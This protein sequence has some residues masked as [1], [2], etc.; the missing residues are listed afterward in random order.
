MRI[1]PHPLKRARRI[2]TPVHEHHAV[3][4]IVTQVL[5]KAQLAHATKV[6]S[7]TLVMGE[8]LGFDPGSVKLY[9]EDISEGTIAQGAEL[10][11]KPVKTGFK[12]KTCNNEFKRSANELI[13]PTC[14]GQQLLVTSGKEWYI[15]SIEVESQDK[16]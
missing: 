10:R 12:C 7:V 8:L 3:R 13:C 5:E 4:D 15:D 6:T 9:F 2:P 1:I 14:C 16:K 11:F